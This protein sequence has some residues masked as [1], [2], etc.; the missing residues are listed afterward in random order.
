MSTET[1]ITHTTKPE[2]TAPA[3]WCGIKSGYPVL[4]GVKLGYPVQTTL[5]GLRQDSQKNAQPA[6]ILFSSNLEAE[7]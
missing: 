6:S 5:G 2:H 3:L 4:C 1:L 7:A